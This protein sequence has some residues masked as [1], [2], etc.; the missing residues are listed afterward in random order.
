MKQLWKMEAKVAMANLPSCYETLASS[1]PIYK[2]MGNACIIKLMQ[3]YVK[4][5]Q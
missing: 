2:L 4:I 1:M 3:L 5:F